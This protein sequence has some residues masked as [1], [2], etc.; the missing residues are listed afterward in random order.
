MCG[1]DVDI[2]SFN[3]KDFVYV[4]DNEPRN[5]EICSRIEKL[6]LRGEKIVIW[7]RSI[8]QKDI[9]DMILTGLNVMDVLKSSVYKGLEATVK[10]NEWKKV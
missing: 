3:F 2:D 10:F 4:L 8:D 9:N 6:I 1:A 7:P 5:K